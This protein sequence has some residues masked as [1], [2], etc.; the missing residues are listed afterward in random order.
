MIRGV[1][2]RPCHMAFAV[3]AVSLAIWMIGCA[4]WVSGVELDRLADR[5]DGRS[6]AL[7]DLRLRGIPELYSR[8]VRSVPFVVAKQGTGSGY[9]LAV[10]KDS[11]AF[12]VTNHHVVEAAFEDAKERYAYVVFHDSE[13]GKAPFERDRLKNCRTIRSTWCEAFSRVV[14]RGTVL[15]VDRGRDLAILAVADAPAGVGPLPHAGPGS[16]RPGDQIVLVGHPINLLWTLTV[17]IVSAVRD[18]FPS[19]VP[20]RTLRVIQTQAPINPGNSGGPLTTLNGEV[21][22]VA[23]AAYKASEG[24]GLAI[25]INEVEAFMG[26]LITSNKGR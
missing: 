6:V 23:F 21:V 14:R 8:L 12:V 9:V 13:L 16:V 25:G 22:G 11:V 18:E 15:G 5:L 7:P 24:L 19:E 10:T 2:K 17:G 4:R 26:E 1:G 20:P 3:A